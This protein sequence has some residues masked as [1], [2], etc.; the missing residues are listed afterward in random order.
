MSKNVKNFTDGAREVW[1]SWRKRRK[2]AQDIII[3][4]DDFE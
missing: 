3:E 1:K 2:L 4:F